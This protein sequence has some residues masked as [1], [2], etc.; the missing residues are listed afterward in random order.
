MPS[1]NVLTVFSRGI[2]LDNL[3]SASV[4]LATL[5]ALKFTSPAPLPAKLAAVIAPLNTFAAFSLGTFALSLASASVP[6][7]TLLAFKFVTPVPSPTCVPVNVAALTPPVNALV[8]AFNLGTFVLSLAS[9]N[10]PALKLLA[11]L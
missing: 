4:P 7:A 6:L 8:A 5:L 2:L 1:A 3:A 10:T 9:A 11:L